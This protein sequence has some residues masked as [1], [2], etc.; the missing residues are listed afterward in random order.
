VT[1]VFDKD[2]GEAVVAM[3]E[4]G[5]DTEKNTPDH[6]IATTK[7]VFIHLRKMGYRVEYK[8][9]PLSRD[10]T[11]IASDIDHMQLQ[12]KCKNPGGRVVHLIMSRSKTGSSCRYVTGLLATA[13]SATDLDVPDSGDMGPLGSSPK[14]FKSSQGLIPAQG[15]HRNIL[16]L[17]RVLEFGPDAKQAVDAAIGRCADIGDLRTDIAE[18]WMAANNPET[19]LEAANETR[20]LGLH[21]LQRYGLLI[22]FRVYLQVNTDPE[23]T[24]SMWKQGRPELGHLM[25]SMKLY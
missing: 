6:G 10:R 25:K 22:M 21:Y 12:L 13:L 4:S 16:N 24:F 15:E 9:I 5:I 2:P 7:Q 19:T 20:Q 18:C 1:R 23:V 17:L 8:R 14:R 3:W 11:P